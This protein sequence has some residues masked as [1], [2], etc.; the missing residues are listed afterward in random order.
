MSIVNQIKGFVRTVLGIP[1]LTLSDCVDEDSIINYTIYGNSVQDG[2]PTPET[3]VD[4][5]SVGE[6]DEEAGKYKIPVICS[7]GN[8]RSVITD[9]YLD[10]P[11]RKVGDCADYIDFE[12]SVVIRNVGMDEFTEN[13]NYPLYFL[14]AYGFYGYYKT[15]KNMKKGTRQAGFCTHIKN[16]RG[17]KSPIWFGVG[18]QTIYF[19]LPDV[20][21]SGTTN[22]EKKQAIKDW[23]AALE[24]PFMA[25]YPLAEITET[26]ISLP[27]LPTFKGTTIYSIDTTIQPSNMEATYKSTSKE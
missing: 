7:N 2:T 27:K 19:S 10:E 9:I 21:N 13:T 1:P 5:E 11:L 18:N 25:Y 23:L 22:D 12:N 17:E 15:I 3:P 20:Y 8:G 6:Y 16:T 4:V 14:E 26:P 24:E